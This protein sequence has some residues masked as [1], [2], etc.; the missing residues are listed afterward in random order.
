MHFNL[1]RR[2]QTFAGAQRLKNTVCV[3]G[4]RVMF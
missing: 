1:K 3:C 4:V 2:D